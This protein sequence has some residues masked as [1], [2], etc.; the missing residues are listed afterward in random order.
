MFQYQGKTALVTGASA[1]IGAEFTRELAARGMNVILVARNE[2]AMNELADEVRGQHGVQTLVISVDL[3]QETAAA[4]VAEKV[5]AIDWEVDLLVNNAGFLTYGPFETNDPAEERKEILVNVAA[6]VAM[7]HEF[8]PGMLARK[9]GGVINVASIAAFQAIPYMAIY[10]ATKA[11]V[12]SFS[13]GL[14]Q[15]CRKRNVHILGLCPGTTSTEIFARGGANILQFDPAPRK[16]DQVVATAL[17]AFE[18]K[19]CLAVDGWKNRLMSYGAKLAPRELSAWFAG[20][21]ARP[22]T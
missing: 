11:F 8:L 20:K 3:S 22:K 10:A 13:I 21:M 9:N 7:T 4:E 1:G 14:Y 12:V 6:L 16:V 19:R 15:E 17:K 18:R 2:A 5:A